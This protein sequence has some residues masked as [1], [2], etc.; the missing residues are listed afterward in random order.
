MTDEELI[1]MSKDVANEF[2]NNK[3][4]VRWARLHSATANL[5]VVR[6]G[7]IVDV[8]PEGWWY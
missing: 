2:L 5:Y 3:D 8:P 7:Q 6:S 4:K 1:I